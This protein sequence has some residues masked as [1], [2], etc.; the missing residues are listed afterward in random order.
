MSISE[1]SLGAGAMT[2][3]VAGAIQELTTRG[4][5]V[6]AN[7]VSDRLTGKIAGAE[8][9]TYRYIR[10][11]YDGLPARIIENIVGSVIFSSLSSGY[12]GDWHVGRDDTLK[13][14]APRQL[15]LGFDLVI[16]L[17]TDAP[18]V[19]EVLPG[20]AKLLPHEI[21]PDSMSVP[22]ALAPGATLI[23]DSRLRRRF[24]SDER[25]LGFSVIRDWLVPVEVWPESDLDEVPDRA[26]RFFGAECLPFT[27]LRDWHRKVHPARSK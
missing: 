17:D 13:S 14:G 18:R 20:S 25:V 12:A 21:V 19:I 5:T 11:L 10:Q 27:N 24:P 16:G 2:P 22:I 26:A 4:Y 3:A 8:T 9:P 15:I 1:N 23:L 6:V 7:S